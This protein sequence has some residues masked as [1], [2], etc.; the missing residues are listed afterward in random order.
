MSLSPFF[1]FVRLFL[2]F[3]NVPKK[4]SLQFFSI[5][6]NRMDLEK[7]QRKNLPPFTVFGIGRFFKV[8]LFRPK[9]S[10]SQ[11]QHAMF[12]FCFFSKNRFFFY[13]TF[14]LFS[15][16]RSTF[17]LETKRFASI[18][19]CSRFSALCDL[20]D[21]FIKIF[22]EIF[23]PNFVIFQCFRF[24][25]VGFLLFPVGEEWFSRFMR[26]P[27]GIFGAVKLIKL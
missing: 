16:H 3:F 2:K 14:F 11:A 5:F 7:F 8:N 10:F 19:E 26:F 4:S 21:T 24:R 15:F 25:K 6:C 12:D 22:F 17:L 23:I 27:S 9:I 20:S 1:G 13:A 18:K